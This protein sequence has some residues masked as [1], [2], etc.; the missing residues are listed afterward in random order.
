VETPRFIEISSVEIKL[1]SVNV[2]LNRGCLRRR[3]R[4]SSYLGLLSVEVKREENRSMI[5][6][7]FPLFIY[8]HYRA[9]LYKQTLKNENS[10]QG[11]R[12][13]TLVYSVLFKRMVWGLIYS[14]LFVVFLEASNKLSPNLGI[15]TTS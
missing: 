15:L 13:K 14:S 11:I 10:R 5:A 8:L 4:H 2:R 1:S 9:I 6:Y 3:I 12:S 7:S